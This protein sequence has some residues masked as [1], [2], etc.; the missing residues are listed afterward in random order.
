MNNPKRLKRRKKDV[1]CQA[2]L[3]GDWITAKRIFYDDPAAVTVKISGIEEITL[4]VARSR[5]RSSLR[6]I[7]MLVE[8]MPEHSLETTNIHGETPLHYAAIAGNIQAISLLLKKNPALLQIANFHGLAPLHFAAQCCHKEAVSL[9][10][11]CDRSKCII[12][13]K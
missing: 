12:R 10:L 1:T 3:R 13:P 9:L 4:H 2:A 8:S 11:S 5:G 7:Q 6:F